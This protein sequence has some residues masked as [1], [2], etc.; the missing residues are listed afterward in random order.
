MPRCINDTSL[1]SIKFYVHISPIF[2]CWVIATLC[3]KTPSVIDS[4]DI[5]WLYL[6]TRGS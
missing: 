3:S 1:K 4:W 5:S 6:V 2:S